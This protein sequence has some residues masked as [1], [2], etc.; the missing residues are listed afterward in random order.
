[1][2]NRALPICIQGVGGQRT[3]VVFLFFS[4]PVGTMVL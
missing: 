2:T 3:G 1:M 4:L